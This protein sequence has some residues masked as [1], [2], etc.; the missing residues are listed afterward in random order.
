MLEARRNYPER[1]ISDTVLNCTSIGRVWLNSENGK[2]EEK[3]LS[4]VA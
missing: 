3:P 2:L 1:W 4:G